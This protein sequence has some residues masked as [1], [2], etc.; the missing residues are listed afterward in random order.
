VN[1][2]TNMNVQIASAAE[3]Q[4][5]VAEEINR[6]IVAINDVTGETSEGATETAAACKKEANL[7]A[8]LQMLVNQFKT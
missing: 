5:A 2:I 1:T 6:N 7:A 3:E 4:S 8:H